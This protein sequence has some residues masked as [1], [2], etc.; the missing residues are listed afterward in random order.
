MKLAAALNLTEPRVVR[1]LGGGIGSATHLIAFRDRRVVLKRYPEGADDPDF[2]W[3]GLTFARDAG[4]LSPEPIALDQAGAW[5][6]CPALVIGVMPGHP[7]LEPTNVDRYVDEVAAAIAAI[8]GVS[9]SGAA[10]GLLRPHSVDRW[11]APDDVPEGLVPS[12]LVARM[13]EEL[14]SGLPRADRGGTVLNHG[15]LHPGNLLWRR[16]R[17]TGVVDW[18][19]TR[20]G[21]RWWEL[22][23]FRMELAVLVDARA[24]DKLLERYQVLV[25]MESPHQ[26]V[27]DLLCLYTGH[28]WGHLWLVG[29]REQGRRDLTLDMMRQRLTR[30][31]RRVLASLGT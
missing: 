9:T 24:A 23:Y 18:S 20:L 8:H 31:A 1:R 6:G 12:A 28:R 19:S 2:E 11:T 30:Q 26:A 15:D 7:D 13:L 16:G 3:Q 10:R 22:A 25:S 4:L 21:P 27:W 5:F 14:R 29:Y 17:L